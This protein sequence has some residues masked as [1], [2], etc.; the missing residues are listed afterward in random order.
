[1]TW[2]WAQVPLDRVVRLTEASPEAI[3]LSLEPLPD[4]APAVISYRPIATTSPT[5]MITNVLDALDTVATAL[6]PAWLPGAELLDGPAGASTAAVRS[7]ARK[8]AA[9]TPDFG[10]FLADLAQRSLA[11]GKPP[12]ATFTVEVRAVGLARVIAT[13]F[14][15]A[16]TAVLV[17]VPDGL[18]PAAERSLA[19]AFEWLVYHGRAGVWLTGDP[20]QTVDRI[21]A[22]AV[23]L[24]G[25]VAEFTRQQ[26]FTDPAPI[27]RTPIS[28]PPL[29]GR[30][31]PASQAEH[32][33]ETALAARPWAMGRT[34]NQIY[35]F[36]PLVN[37]VRLDL[38]WS[39]ERCVVEVDGP[40]HCGL[41]R[42]EADRRRDVDLQLD[43]FAVLRFT[44]TQ[45]L[46]DLDA[47]L[48]RIERFIRTRR[49]GQ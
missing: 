7:L 37:P 23:D 8:A 24:T 34:W 5:S 16:R 13:A 49:Q 15:R 12:T 2:S 26:M 33:L 22:A 28:Y 29:A 48:L 1:M 39:A 18:T 36:G 20:L 47:V 44:N 3:E 14:G 35:R 6:F 31:H 38:A 43:G 27:E 4:D 41:A 9:T 30:P 19:T 25:T 17:Q 21:C 40:E 11:G 10:P 45:I 32:I 42:Y 46:H